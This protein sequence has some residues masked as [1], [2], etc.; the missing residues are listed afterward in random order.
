MSDPL[1]DLLKDRPFEIPDLPEPGPTAEELLEQRGKAFTRKAAAADARRLIPIKINIEGPIGLALFGDPHVDDDGTDIAALQRDVAIVNRTP[2]MLAGN[3]GDYRNNWIGRLARLW[4]EQSTSARDAR[5][6][7]E[8]LL[9]ACPWL[10]LVQGNHDCWSGADDPIEWIAAQIHALAQPFQ[11]RMELGFPNGK[12][13]RVNARHDFKGRSLYNAAHGVMRAA[14]FGWRD[15]LLVC[16]HTHVSGY[17]PLKDP[18]SG[19]ISHAIR[20][21]SYKVFDAHAIASG[22]DDE[23]IFKCPV[24][25]IQPQYDDNDPRLLTMMFDAETAADFLTFLK[26]KKS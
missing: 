10:F 20:V 5:V 19:L 2:G 14:K 13:V 15:H 18:S 3:V 8:W 25:I 6:L 21:A 7:A 26:A 16:G 24:V 11:V 12:R 4:G 9:K 22:F 23:N 1:I 17:A